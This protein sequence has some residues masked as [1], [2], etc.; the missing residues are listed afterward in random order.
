MIMITLAV[1]PAMIVNVIIFCNCTAIIASLYCSMVMMCCCEYQGN[2]C[3]RGVGIHSDP[4]E[5]Q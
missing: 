4:A 2:Y 5:S 1:I 3:S